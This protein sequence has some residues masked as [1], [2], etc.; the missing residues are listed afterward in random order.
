VLN[1][2]IRDLI[3]CESL[4]VSRVAQ[5]VAGRLECRAA[6]GIRS[7]EVR[8]ILS[9]RLGFAVAGW[10]GRFPGEAEIR[11]DVYLVDAYLHGISVKL[12]AG[13]AL[14]VKVYQ[15]SPG[16]FEVAGRAL[17][18]L[19]YWQKWSFPCDGL[20]RE[21][22]GSVGWV[23]VRK[24]RR[25]SRFSLA[26]GETGSAVE[27]T[28]VRARDEDWWSLGI[29]A[30]GPHDLLRSELEAVTARVFA[31]PPP[32]LADFGPHNSRSFADWLRDA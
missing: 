23:P 16:V 27:L 29:E 14:E 8:W 31:T 7:L 28:E 18:R 5:V 9:G 11:E 19:E 3:A 22:V 17:G 10:H 4:P 26:G 24:R 32:D 6:E 1:L 12:R 20:S 30:T 21:D 15:G 2:D 25:I 13:T